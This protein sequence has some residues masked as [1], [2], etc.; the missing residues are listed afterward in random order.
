MD[1][2]DLEHA[3]AERI[4][5]SGAKFNVGVCVHVPH[6]MRLEQSGYDDIWLQRHIGVYLNKLDRRIHKAAHKNRGLRIKRVVALEHTVGVGWHSHM[7]VETPQNM[8]DDELIEE[9]GSVWLRY[10]GKWQNSGFSNDRLFWAEQIEE[11]Y[12]QYT[13]KNG[14]NIL[15]GNMDWLNT[16]IG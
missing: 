10:V 16:Y 11:G 7:C 8:T 15:N 12:S 1:K 5:E 3:L 13:T 4:K 9:M 2:N 6:K 14:K